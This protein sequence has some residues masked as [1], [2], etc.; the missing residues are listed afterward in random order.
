M[1][2]HKT[3]KHKTA[4]SQDFKPPSL[5]H[6]DSFT[7]I[8]STAYCPRSKVVEDRLHNAKKLSLSVSR[9]A[10]DISDNAHSPMTKEK[11]EN[12]RLDRMQHF[13]IDLKKEKWTGKNNAS[14][15][16][17]LINYSTGKRKV[18]E[19]VDARSS[20]DM[21]NMF[22]TTAITTLNNLRLEHSPN[23]T[24]S[25]SENIDV[26]DGR[27]NEHHRNMTQ[28]YSPLSFKD[29]RNL[30]TTGSAT[31]VERQGSI[32]SIR[33]FEIEKLL[34]GE[35]ER[36]LGGLL[37]KDNMEMFKSIQDKLSSLY[38]EKR[39]LQESIAQMQSLL[40]ESS[41]EAQYL[42]RANGIV[43]DE[44]QKILLGNEQIDHY[45]KKDA[46]VLQ[47]MRKEVEIIQNE[48]NKKQ[49]KLSTLK[50]FLTREKFYKSELE[51]TVAKLQRELAIQI[52]EK[53]HTKNLLD[54]SL[55]QM[56]VY[57][58]KYFTYKKTQSAIKETLNS[59][60]NSSLSSRFSTNRNKSVS[61]KI[62]FY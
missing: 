10:I 61:H 59:S 36:K 37:T 2:K 24:L 13:E 46:G 29:L 18:G 45:Y 30:N 32:G 9:K 44:C 54:S 19:N 52:K 49:Q 48:A 47:D 23:R 31:K 35:K 27:V 56:N 14:G 50:S 25:L 43:K 15:R 39:Q 7:K 16:S 55:R 53:G 40:K 3:S 17:N 57:K 12:V 1:Q 26:F 34:P 5:K 21:T 42:K 51:R 8:R 11:K 28:N 62:E 20:L 60:I 41:D 4:L 33:G 22:N 6:Q 58:S 38:E